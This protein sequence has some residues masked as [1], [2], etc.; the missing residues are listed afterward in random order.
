MAKLLYSFTCTAGLISSLST[1]INK[2]ERQQVVYKGKHK[3]PPHL[4]KKLLSYTCRWI[5]I[6]SVFSFDWIHSET[7]FPFSTNAEFQCIFFLFDH[8]TKKDTNML[9]ETLQ[10]ATPDINWL[11]SY[12][13]AVQL[14]KWFPLSASLSMNSLAQTH[15]HTEF[16]ETFPHAHRWHPTFHSVVPATVWSGWLGLTRD[17]VKRCQFT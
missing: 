13:V 14:M 5:K 15:L 9:S 17:T 7:G 3:T 10:R 4:K 11:G 8:L 6:F 16:W 1:L 12:T 2:Q